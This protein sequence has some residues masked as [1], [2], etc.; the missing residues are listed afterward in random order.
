[1]YCFTLIQGRDTNFIHFSEP[2][3][4]ITKQERLE[5]PELKRVLAQNIYDNVKNSITYLEETQYNPCECNHC[6]RDI[7]DATLQDTELRK[8]VSISKL[9]YKEESAKAYVEDREITQNSPQ[10]IS[11]VE[12]ETTL[13]PKTYNILKNLEDSLQIHQSIPPLNCESFAEFTPRSSPHQKSQRLPKEEDKMDK[14]R[15][16]EYSPMNGFGYNHNNVMDANG[17]CTNTYNRELANLTM[18]Q[19]NMHGRN[20]LMFE[21]GNIPYGLYGQSNYTGTN[22]LMCGGTAP[23]HDPKMMYRR[24]HETNEPFY[25]HYPMGSGMGYNMPFLPPQAYY[26]NMKR[27]LTKEGYTHGC[28][29]MNNNASNN[30]ALPKYP[31]ESVSDNCPKK[32]SYRKNLSKVKKGDIDINIETSSSSRKGVIIDLNIGVGN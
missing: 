23:S 32:E 7:A 21:D 17:F 1:M 24:N 29:Y 28:H 14:Q 22:S 6:R 12:G 18:Q 19:H 5:D 9:G 25:N 30:G 2:Y 3:H 10:P 27:N 20:N 4:K 15:Y 26:P 11:A 8:N 13:H 16:G 31:S